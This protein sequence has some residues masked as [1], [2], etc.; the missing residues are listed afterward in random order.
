MYDTILIPT[1]G[2]DHSTRAAEHGLYLADVF[3]ATV[4]VISAVD[5]QAAAGPFDVGGVVSEFVEELETAATEAI[6]DILALTSDPS[7]VETAVLEGDPEEVI[8]DYAA[9]HDVDLLAMG[10]HGRDG[11]D[12]YVAGSVC[13]STLRHAS[14]PVLTTRA[15]E[16]S[17]PAEAYEEILIPTDGSTAS[18]AAIEHGVAIASAVDARVHAVNVIDLGDVTASSEYSIPTQLIETLEERGEAATAAVA[19]HAAAAD[20]D[21]TTSVISG[22]PARDLLE[23]AEAND[24]DLITMGTAGRTGLDRFLMGST[25][26]RVVR[27]ANVPVLSVNARGHPEER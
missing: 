15:T 24:V 2:S 3:D 12:R 1:D 11:L 4:H 16:E 14:M 25:T 8:M 9:D 7:T 18:E 27:H 13:E 20:L 5:V 21:V 17:H 26:E 6:D 23:Y 19:E 10:T 22:F